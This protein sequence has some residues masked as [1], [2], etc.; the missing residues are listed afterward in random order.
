MNNEHF[1][2]PYNFIPLSDKSVPREESSIKKT[3]E[4]YSGVIEYSIYT[5]TPLFIPNTSND[6]ALGVKA[7]IMDETGKGQETE[8]KSYD[9]FSYTNLK[10]RNQEESISKY[11][12]QQPVIPG[13]E[14]RGMLRS[15]FEILTNSCM[16]AIDDD[17]VLSKRTVEVYKAGLIKKE[18]GNY[19][20]YE[21]ED[22]LLRTKGENQRRKEDIDSIWDV[23]KLSNKEKREKYARKCYRQKDFRE[24]EK[25]FIT[26]KN[27]QG[28][29]L[30]TEILKEDELVGSVNGYTEG[31]VIMGEDGPEMAKGNAA[32]THKHCCH[33]FVAKKEKKTLQDKDIQKLKKIL[34]IYDKNESGRYKKYREELE[35]FTRKCEN[36]GRFFPVY[37]SYI[38]RKKQ[39]N[40]SLSPASITREIYDKKLLEIIR[41]HGHQSCNSKQQL[42]P[43][44]RLFGTINRDAD[45]RDFALATR[46]RISD[47]LIDEQSFNEAERNNQNLYHKITTLNPLASPKISNMEFYVSKPKGAIFWTYDYYIDQN[48]SLYFY[49]DKIPCEIN[50]RKFYWHNMFPDMTNDTPSQLNITIRPLKENIRFR[51][52]VY[53]ND[54]TK[55]ELDELIY[56][57]NAGDV[58][59]RNNQDYIRLKKHGYKLGHGKPLGL[60]SIAI[61]TEKVI[62]YS[63][64]LDDVHQKIVKKEEN[65]NDYIMPEFDKEIVDRFEIMTNFLSAFYS[66]KHQKMSDDFETMEDFEAKKGKIKNIPIKYPY[67]EKESPSKSNHMAENEQEDESKIFE[68]FVNNHR[69]RKAKANKDGTLRFDSG[70]AKIGQYREQM[71]YESYMKP[72]EPV[73]EEVA[74]FSQEHKEKKLEA[75]VIKNKKGTLT[76]KLKNGSE[77]KIAPKYLEGKTIELQDKISVV[78][79]K[80]VG[81]IQFYKIV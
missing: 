70:E 48:G 3:E 26:K 57:L 10:E 81:E 61:N 63:Y 21:A 30:V 11:E 2:N 8:H 6:K 13:S 28:K 66:D 5:K 23:D 59:L 69:L 33:I 80:K 55:T 74:D 12:C 37:Y 58:D 54:I 77:G 40:V 29:S 64:L 17:V 67:K 31:Y 27:K 79:D 35:E 41:K 14:M 24:G 49:S 38:D 25:V 36:E 4:L 62:L 68:W 73:L 44:C 46:I 16:S 56:L 71:F 65:Y 19:Y 34:E 47:L 7:S 51:G 75:T 9:F 78:P 32:K 15:N 20:L 22:C 76:I 1:I 60:G 42:C 72:M 43:A 45:G 39:S 18:K 52:K 53:F 50:G